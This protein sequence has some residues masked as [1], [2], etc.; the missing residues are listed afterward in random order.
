MDIVIRNC[1][2]IDTARIAVT[3]GRLNIKYGINGTGKSSVAHA[4]ELA[5]TGQDLTQLLP[6]K[7]LNETPL[8]EEHTPSVVFSKPLNGVAIFNEEYVNQYLFRSDEL[9]ANSFEI[10]VKTPDYDERM[11][12]IQNLIKDIQNTFR[13]NPELDELI[14]DLTTFISGFGK[15]KSGYSKTGA[16]GK[17]IA[18]GNKIANVPTSLSEYT[19]YIQSGKNLSWLSWQCKG[20]DYLDVAE[21]CPY[22]A[23]KLPSARKEIAKQVAIEYDSKYVAELQKIVETLQ[24][25]RMYFT[26]DVQNTLDELAVNSSGFGKAEIDYLKYLKDQVV[27][28]NSCLI[29]IKTLNFET[30]KD[31]DAVVKEL[32][33]KK[34]KLALLPALNSEY[35]A[36]KVS[37]VN[38]ALEHVR[39]QAGVLQGA[40]NKQKRHIKSTIE[41]YKEE[42]NGFLE[43]AGYS[44]NVS[45]IEDPEKETYRLVLFSTDASVQIQD[46]KSH[47]SYGERNAFALV[48]FMYC[49]LKDNSSLVILDD[50]ISSFDKNK[51]YAIMEMLF[52]GFKGKESFRGKTVVMLTHDFDPIVDLIHTLTIGRTFRPAPVA[53]FLYNEDG[54]LSEKEITATDIQSFFEIANTNI[55]SDIDEINKLIYLRRRLEACGDKG[56]AWQLLSNIF[57]PNRVIPI[58]QDL[59]GERE[60]TCEEIAEAS[61]KIEEE[62]PDFDYA[63]IYARAHDQ[64]QMIA[65]YNSLTSPYE[66]VQLYRIV[67]HGQISDSVFKKFVDESYHIE[68]DSLFQLNP[69][70]YPTIPRYIVQLCDNGIR[71]LEEQ[72]G[73]N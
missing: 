60:M 12:V 65:L 68:N 15:A 18:K 54:M 16:I 59:L 61:A 70:E 46:V 20:E 24:S 57:H 26:D 49:V 63:R 67:N 48:L 41:K 23:G 66:K 29:D 38:R 50:P 53:A 52:K 3:D 34:I 33:R 73:K 25:L 40:V 30:L 36:A 39:E 58:V 13:D 55:K 69:S 42:I 5:A 37:L 32:D 11:R 51:K 8:S 72:L 62:I 1:N 2:N 27:N 6:Y 7:Y 44:Y 21:Q 9:V 47:L 19:P 31:V 10:F 64:K 56:L 35:T 22:C 43:S 4:I 28:L 14:G 45:I 71:L 17:G